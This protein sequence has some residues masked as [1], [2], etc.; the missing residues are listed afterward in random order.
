MN[1]RFTA[2]PIISLA[3]L[4]LMGCGRG[5]LQGPTTDAPVVKPSDEV[6]ER[7]ISG[8]EIARI[9]DAAKS[10]D[11]A[12]VK[13]LVAEKPELAGARY[14]ESLTPL[15]LAAGHGHK[16]VAGFLVTHGAEVNARNE[17]GQTI[18]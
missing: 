16:Q 7:T 1:T 12:K 4:M 2:V 17:K 14:Y 11:F 13:S 10:G 18:R 8:S 3:A 6:K 15:H 5:D 9:M